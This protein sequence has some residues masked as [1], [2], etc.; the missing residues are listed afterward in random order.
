MPSPGTAARLAPASG[1]DC[2]TITILSVLD[3]EHHE[4]SNDSRARV[5]NKLPCV[6]V[7][8]EMAADRPD[9]HDQN[10]SA[11]GERLPC[12]VSDRRRRIGEQ[13]GER[14]WLAVFVRAF[15]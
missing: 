6:R 9:E 5:Y 4:K 3:Q 13:P 7:S 11:E 2:G 15:H 12:R 14:V 1:R 10:A 8:E